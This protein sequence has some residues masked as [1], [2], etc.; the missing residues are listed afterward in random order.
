MRF[1]HSFLATITSNALCEPLAILSVLWEGSA[2]RIEPTPRVP[3]D[4]LDRLPASVSIRNARQLPDAILAVILANATSGSPRGHWWP[5]PNR[6]SLSESETGVELEALAQHLTFGNLVP[7]RDTSTSA[8]SLTSLQSIARQTG[9][10]AAVYS[11][12]GAPVLVIEADGGV[13]ALAS[14]STCEQLRPTTI[15]PHPSQSKHLPCLR[16]A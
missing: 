10:S 15:R 13:A 11:A 16:A 14:L 2:S 7:F 8:R 6:A 9:A 12:D 5:V 1:E 3:L 4:G